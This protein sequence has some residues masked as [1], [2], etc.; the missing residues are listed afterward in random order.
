MN[1]DIAWASGHYAG[2]AEMVEDRGA[3]GAIVRF[4][5]AGAKQTIWCSSGEIIAGRV[6][7][8]ATKRTESERSLDVGP[9]LPR[10][11]SGRCPTCG[12]MR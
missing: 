7:P 12:R 3:R 9:E 11:T 8:K 10:Q 1:I 5:W 2:P 6:E 4:P